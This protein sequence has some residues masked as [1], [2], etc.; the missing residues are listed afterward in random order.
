MTVSTIKERNERERVK[1]DG[2]DNHVVF[3]L[4]SAGTIR[5]E[6]YSVLIVTRIIARD[7]Q[8][9]PLGSQNQISTQNNFHPSKL[10]KP[11]NVAN[12]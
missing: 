12:I 10:L 7:V 3:V 6:F 8:R 2:E 5:F 9:L 11:M 4:H 1:K